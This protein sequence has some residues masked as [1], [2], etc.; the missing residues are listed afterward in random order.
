MTAGAIAAVA[1]AAAAE[2]AEDGIIIIT[3]TTT[4]MYFILVFLV[5]YLPIY[6]PLLMYVCVDCT[7]RTCRFAVTMHAVGYLR[8]II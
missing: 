4:G 6:L 5:R 7:L 1:A 8:H 3:T 2:W